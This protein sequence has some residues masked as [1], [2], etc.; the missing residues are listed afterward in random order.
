[1]EEPTI[2]GVRLVKG[3]MYRLATITPPQRK[4]RHHCMTYLGGGYWN[5][6]PFAGTQQVDPSTI[7]S[8]E[9]VRDNPARESSD[10][11]MNRRA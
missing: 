10:H 2:N 8:I 6:R 3:Y 4:A 1:M 9:P 5:A 7:A 11:Y